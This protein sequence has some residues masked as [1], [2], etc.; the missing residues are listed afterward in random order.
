MRTY[1]ELLKIPGVKRLVV[2]ALPGRMAYAMIALAT[3]F[4][5]QDQTGSITLAGIATGVE[6][7]SSSLTAG[8]RGNLID[9]WGQTKPLSIF[10]PSW[11]AL[12]IILSEVS[13]P[14]AIVIV[15][16]LIGLASPPVNL[17]ARP[18][19]RVLVGAENLRTAYALD[20]TISS[21]TIVAGP[22]LAT[23]IAIPISGSAAL[24]ATAA[25]MGIGGFAMIQM[26]ASRN[27]KPEP[28]QGTS[29]TLLR[30][31]QFQILAVEGLVFGLAWGLLEIS[32]PAFS[33]LQG[34]PEL[35][36]PLLATLAGASI[37][38]GLL[39]GSR[40]SLTTPLQ[41]FKWASLGASV[42][43]IP[44]VFTEPGWSMA[45]VLGLLGL[46]MGFA[47]VF[48][49]EVLEAVRP[50]GT[51]TSAQAW[52]WAVEGSMLAVG[53]ALGGYLVENV[54]PQSALL[55]V[56]VGL[57]I[58]TV[59]IWIYAASRL[60]QADKPLSESQM[61]EVIADLESPAE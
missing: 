8:F 30:N 37:V 13:T 55:G 23:A 18:L 2:S 16:G 21:S 4:F 35:S 22:V 11:V 26:P 36:A 1:L 6:T 60:S 28:T 44:L 7:I 20:T 53:T 14:T 29:L 3:F 17:S 47:Q 32:I 12:V 48:H 31:K 25:L 41:G 57:I 46:G 10:V 43:A 19:W 59:Y 5:V 38:G 9:K 15:S 52:L 40:K 61:I 49:W 51:A 56:S 24:W 58:S 50:Q 34:T 33:T 54:S 27:W 42:A 39:I 45:I